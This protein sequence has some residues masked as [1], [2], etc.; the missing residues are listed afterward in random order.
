MERLQ[1]QSSLSEL[2]RFAQEARDGAGRLVLVAGEAG[3]NKTR[4]AQI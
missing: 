1:R 2:A 3:V 4:E